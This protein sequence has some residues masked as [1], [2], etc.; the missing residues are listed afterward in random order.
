MKK[1][2]VALTAMGIMVGSIATIS[3]ASSERYHKVINQDYNNRF[4]GS[5]YYDIGW[6][7][8][9]VYPGYKSY[10][11]V[12]L[13]KNGYWQADCTTIVSGGNTLT[14]YSGK[15]QG[16]GST[17]VKSTIWDYGPYN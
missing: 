5:Y 6:C 7:K 13:K 10:V 3:L 14:C 1:L 8:T 9:K 4:N 17:A 16:S 15:I 2:I 12:S 11:E